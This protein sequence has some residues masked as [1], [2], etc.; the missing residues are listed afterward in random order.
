[1]I[2]PAP[3]KEQMDLPLE[4]GAAI[5]AWWSDGWW[6]GIITGVGSCDD[7]F[8][9]Y[10]PGMLSRIEYSFC[11]FMLIFLLHFLSKFSLFFF[12]FYCNYCGA[13]RG[14]LT[15]EHGQKGSKNIQR[16]VGGPVG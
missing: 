14:K 15:L 5:D 6:E 1:M 11:P 12:G 2:R 4:V 13:I 10:F 9:V 3:P 16:L 7:N 8:Q